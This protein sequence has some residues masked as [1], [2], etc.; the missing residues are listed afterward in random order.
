MLMKID[1]LI[2]KGEVMEIDTDAFEGLDCKIVEIYCW[3]VD[4]KAKSS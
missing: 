3:E 2:E 1:Q 4:G